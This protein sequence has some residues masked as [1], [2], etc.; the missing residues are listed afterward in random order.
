M[1]GK[2]DESMVTESFVRMVVESFNGLLIQGGR[3]ERYE[4]S[5]ND[6]PVFTDVKLILVGENETVIVYSKA[7]FRQENCNSEHHMRGVLV[8]SYFDILGAMTLS[9]D[10][11]GQT[12]DGQK[13]VIRNFKTIY[14]EGLAL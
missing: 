7:H 11:V 12:L 9:E 4:F 6:G 2:F 14:K 5:V 1:I 10:Y 13:V 8:R 3:P